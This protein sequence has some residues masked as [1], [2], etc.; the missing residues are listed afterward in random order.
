[1][2]LYADI[3]NFIPL[4]V[5]SQA[6]RALFIIIASALKSISFVGIVKTL[7]N[8]GANFYSVN[9]ASF[10]ILKRASTLI[11]SGSAFLTSLGK[12]NYN[13]KRDERKLLIL[14]ETFTL[15]NRLKLFAL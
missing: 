9:R 8:L 7:K 15:L 6:S 13:T 11:S 14:V 1:M 2:S 3:N 4:C 10:F 12:N 5:K